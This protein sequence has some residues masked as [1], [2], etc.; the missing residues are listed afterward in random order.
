MHYVRLLRPPLVEASSAGASLKIV[1]TV[2]TDLGD[3]FL[4]PR[5]PIE[6]AVIGAVTEHKDGSSRL[7]P[8]NLTQ[9]KIP[10]WRAG[11]R[12]LKFD[13][14]L[15]RQPVTTIQIRPSS[16]HLTALGTSDI[17]PAKHG[18]IMAAFAD[19]SPPA[20]SNAVCFRSLRLPGAD[21]AAGQTLQ[22]EEDTGETII[23][24]VWD[25]GIVAVSLIAGLLLDGPARHSEPA[26]PLLRS[27]L[28]SPA[29]P[30]NI[31]ELGCGVGVLGIG[32]ARILA[33]VEGSSTTHILM[34]DLPGAEERT[35]ANMARQT[36]GPDQRPIQLDFEPLDWEEGQNGVFGE[37]V[38]SRAW[39]LVVLSDCTYNTDTL[40][41]LV[42]TLS[43]LCRHSAG[44]S[45]GAGRCVETQ[46]LVA[47]KPRHSSERNFFDMMA[48]NTWS[49]REQTAVPLPVLDGQDQSVEVY[50]FGMQGE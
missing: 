35:R 28:H 2:T 23:R 39:D 4:S 32:L 3:S 15:P 49:I 42:K 47:T 14:P 12:V 41:P 21:V 16:R 33:M 29:R 37:K 26:L 11:M 48:A 6:L 45:P 34:T 1:L 27:V 13:V 19:I 8:V 20:S 50:L 24:R 17:F 36:G 22:V 40:L 43:A 7:V 9:G 31:L 30:L 5:E 10:T 44:Q 38:R 18:L 46:V 25:G